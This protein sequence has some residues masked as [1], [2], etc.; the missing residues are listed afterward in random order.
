VKTGKKEV[1][2]LKRKKKK[3]W[4]LLPKTVGEDTRTKQNQVK[5]KMG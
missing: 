1:S 4:K 2:G 5:A 3:G